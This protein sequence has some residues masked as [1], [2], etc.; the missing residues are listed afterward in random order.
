MKHKQK[1][2]LG[3]SIYDAATLASGL[4]HP[5][6]PVAMKLGKSAY[7]SFNNQQNQIEQPQL[8]QAILNEYP[9]MGVKGTPLFRY[10]GK[11]KYVQGGFTKP[12]S[13]DAIQFKGNTHEQGGINIG[14]I[15]VE[16]NEVM[17]NINN[18]QFISSD[19]LTNP[20]TGN[21]F[22]S[23]MKQLEEKKAKF[24]SKLDLNK[25]DRALNSTINL[26]QNQINDL[27]NQQEQL[28]NNLGLNQQQEQRSFQLGGL[29][30]G[31]DNEE[32]EVNKK[33][34]YLDYLSKGSDVLLNLPYNTVMESM[35]QRKFQAPKAIQPTSNLNLDRFT[36]DVQLRDV[37]EQTRTMG[38]LVGGMN[39][40]QRGSRLGSLL[41]KSIKAKGDIRKNIQD[42][43]KEIGIKEDLT[44]LDIERLNKQQKAQ[45]QNQLVQFEN[46][47]RQR[48]LNTGQADISQLRQLRNTQKQQNLLN[49]GQLID[50]LTADPRVIETMLGGI[51]DE[52]KLKQIKELLNLI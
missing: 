4:I 31:D 6:L 49:R 5:A 19:K 40:Q 9:T 43:N 10:G 23:D 27:A 18:E 26:I 22:A 14:N 11:T 29:L 35:T 16:N 51:Q 13:D 47:K 8:N 21:S 12:V 42:V 7:N 44:N 24:Q 46:E 50:L 34:K 39:V 2:N 1:Y 36:A 52:D 17:S 37:D 30:D 38:N 45:Y 15:E 32:D 41:S 33:N 28:K 20:N 3:G 48:L 25:N